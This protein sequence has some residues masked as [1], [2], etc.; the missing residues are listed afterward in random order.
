MPGTELDT[1]R[2]SVENKTNK[3][4]ALTK[5]SLGEITSKEQVITT[6]Y[7]EGCDGRIWSPMSQREPE[8]AAA[9]PSPR[10]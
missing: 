5:F 4:S 6:Q 10:V 8:E 2:H 3:L 7:G 1:W 9:E